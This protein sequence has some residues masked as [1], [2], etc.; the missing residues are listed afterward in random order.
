MRSYARPSSSAAHNTFW[1]LTELARP[2]IVSMANSLPP[3]RFHPPRLR[4]D[5]AAM[6]KLY[7]HWLSPFSRNVRILLKETG[8]DFQLEVE[9]TWERR[10]DSPALHH[11]GLVPV[12][13][14]GRASCW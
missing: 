3:I 10:E 14:I 12:L 9:K 5:S 11:A 6:R 2:Q 8:L 4:L 13:E 1:T 7:H